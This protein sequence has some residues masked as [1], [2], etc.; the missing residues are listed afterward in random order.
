MYRKFGRC[1]HTGN[2]ITL[3]AFIICCSVF[4]NVRVY[5]VSSYRLSRG[6][7]SPVLKAL[8]IAVVDDPCNVRKSSWLAMYDEANGSMKRLAIP[9]NVYPC[10]FAWAPGRDAFAVTEFEGLTFFQKDDSSHRYT[11]RAIRCPRNTLCMDC[12][13]FPNGEWLA[14]IC[15]DRKSF[16]LCRLGLYKYGDRKLVKTG[17]EI[18]HYGLAWGHDGLLYAT[19]D[20]RVVTVELKDGEPRVVRTVPTKLTEA[21]GLF[22]GMFG[23]QPLFQEYEGIRLGDKTL[24]TLMQPGARVSVIATEAIVFVSTS[25]GQLVAFDR[26]GH[27]ISRSDPKRL[28]KF[29]SIKDPNTVY[30]VVDTNLVR[31]CVEKDSLSMDTVIDLHKAS[32]N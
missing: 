5:G 23:D 9:G 26:S 15:P 18:D 17:L 10:Y 7:Y 22:Y 19:N 20:K 13:W 14:V 27:E 11:Q 6:G 29:G 1:C 16:G 8:L 31:I 21:L 30:A 32:R 24:V 28:I 2:R 12:S 4:S 25:P 3:F